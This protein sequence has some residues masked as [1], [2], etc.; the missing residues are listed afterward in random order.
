MF[1][2]QT[3]IVWSYTLWS[4][5]AISLISIIGIL[6]IS[7]NKKLLNKVL[8]LLVSLSA[9]VLIGDAF[10]HL[11]PEA[12]VD[13]MSINISI[14]ILLGITLFFILEKFIHWRHCHVHPSKSH[15]KSY[16]IMNLVGDAF[17]NL[18]DGIIIAGSYMVDI[19]L[20]MAT[21]LAVILH[22]IPQEV[23][24]FGV[25][26]HAGFKKGKA[27]LFNFLT[28]LTA[29]L[30]A[31]ITLIVGSNIS[32]LPEYLIPLT[33]GGFIYIAASDLIPQIHHHHKKDIK[34][35]QSLLELGIFILGILMMYGILF[36]E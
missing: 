1:D 12:T 19:K 15:P 36:L 32:T 11:I 21:T 6:T 27:I 8:I 14:M 29:I 7:M 23:G 13:G 10:L 5:I 4:V 30:G 35:G 22:E 24:D 26:L 31:V 17:H 33:A 3:P 34:L 25:L 18:L 2:V 9:G 20:G 28:A 16:A